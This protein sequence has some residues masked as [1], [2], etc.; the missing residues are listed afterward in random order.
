M[1]ATKLR[2]LITVALLWAMTLNVSATTPG[3]Y[4]VY[5]CPQCET[6]IQKPSINSGNSAGSVLY[7]DGYTFMPFLPQFPDLTKCAK[8]DALFFLKSMEPV[9]TYEFGEAAPEEWRD[10]EFAP[11]PTTEDLRRALELDTIKNNKIA[12]MQLR[13]QIW[14]KFNDRVRDLTTRLTLLS[15]ILTVLPGMDTP[16]HELVQEL[17]PGLLMPGDL[18]DD[19]QDAVQDAAIWPITLSGMSHV[20]LVIM[21]HERMRETAKQQLRSIEIPFATKEKAFWK[22]NCKKL[23]P[24]L[25]PQD[26]NQQIMRAELYR[27][28]GQF[29]KCRA[30]IQELD[31]DLA[32]LKVQ[33]LAECEKRNHRLIVLERPA[34]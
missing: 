19:V 18:Q 14:W 27:N 21:N 10:V 4:Y 2:V 16:P 32:W 3:P 30:I 12:E 13:M 28:L 25:D 33:Y 8:C 7:S 15:K 24:L 26:L 20:D 17:M 11:F 34:R 6:L 9:G 5:K 29:A 31:K 1:N 22:Q 23:L